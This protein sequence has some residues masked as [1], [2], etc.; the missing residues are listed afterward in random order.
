MSCFQLQIVRFTAH[1]V[2][3]SVIGQVILKWAPGSRFWPRHVQL[4]RSIGSPHVRFYNLGAIQRRLD[5]DILVA[6][7]PPPHGRDLELLS[8]AEV[9]ARC[10]EVLH[11]M[12]DRAPSAPSSPRWFTDVYDDEPES[13]TIRLEQMSDEEEEAFHS[14][15]AEHERQLVARKREQKNGGSEWIVE[16]REDDKWQRKPVV[17][18]HSIA[19]TK[20]SEDPFALGAYSCGQLPSTF[21]FVLEAM[22]RS[23]RFWLACCGCCV[24]CRCTAV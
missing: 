17:P 21:A 24:E 18:P 4:L 16:G 20:W 14:R 22:L 6:H 5:V 3:A 9:Q 7:F 12:F 15:G 10:M 2:H 13:A 11:D 19:V 8:L 23:S 1:N